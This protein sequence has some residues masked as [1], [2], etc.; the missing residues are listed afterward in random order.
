MS[1]PTI[2]AI[3]AMGLLGGPAVYGYLFLRAPWHWAEL[4]AVA[5][6]RILRLLLLGGVPLGLLVGLAALLA[7]LLVDHP[8]AAASGGL[9][10]VIA[11]AAWLDRSTRG[12]DAVARLAPQL[13]DPTKAR[14]AFEEIVAVAEAAP[15]G[16]PVG[17]SVRVA[18]ATALGNAGHDREA[19]PLLEAF[20]PDGLSAHER[21]LYWMQTVDSL[22]VMGELERARKALTQVPLIEE[23]SAHAPVLPVLEARLLLWEGKPR[24]AL[25]L[26]AG[27]MPDKANERGRHVVRAHAYAA[28]GELERS[29]ESLRW[30]QT[31]FGEAGL[32]RLF[33]PEGPASIH[34]RAWLNR[35]PGPYRG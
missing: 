13:D 10:V 11:L 20:K 26:V 29:E 12:I 33:E 19:L 32:R 1:V 16:D 14:Q 18:A 35:G 25:V 4:D 22:I 21:E 23:A 3:V 7:S 31:E 30:I 28:L 27:S 17:Q 8:A 2:F 9:L 24:E 6:R 15:P 5:R 34:A